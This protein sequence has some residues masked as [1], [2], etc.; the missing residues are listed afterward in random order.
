MAI[1]ARR[2]PVLLALLAFAARDAAAAPRP[3]DRARLHGLY[4]DGEFE[5]VVR[6][7][8]AYGKGACACSRD[9]SVFAEKYLAVV[10]AANPVTRE[11][12]RYHMHRLLD[13]SPRADLLDMYIGEEVDGV[14]EKVRKEHAL[15]AADPAA[16]PAVVGRVPAPENRASL[17]TASAHPASVPSA[18]KVSAASPS[19]P[20]PSAE[21]TSP[22]PKSYSDAWARLPATLGSS[23]RSVTAGTSARS[24]APAAA[25]RPIAFAPSVR[26]LPPAA[27]ASRANIPS[28]SIAALR[29]RSAPARA[30]AYSPWDQIASAPAAA[31]STVPAAAK[32]GSGGANDRVSRPASEA[33]AAFEPSIS[34]APSLSSAASL[35]SAPPGSATSKPEADTSRPAWK[36]PGLWIGGGAAIAAIAFTLW[37]AG[38]ENGDPAKAYAVPASLDK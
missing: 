7:L 37:H 21:P 30:K 38:S 11:L 10:L 17:P 28:R 34:S 12:G 16:K 13:L 18:A 22:P 27:A 8:A 29:P 20:V 6:E 32:P 26:P 19:T 36:E 33:G 14:F 25:S 9:D 31:G 35:T 23:G 24:V 5:K 15:R 2:I 1:P 3:L 4:Q